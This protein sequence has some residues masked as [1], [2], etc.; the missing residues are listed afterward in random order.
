[1]EARRKIIKET[2]AA[3]KVLAKAGITC[4]YDTFVLI[5]T[6]VF[7]FKSSTQTPRLQQDKNR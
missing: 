3:N 4:Y 5:Q 2:A 6:L 1:M 7:Q